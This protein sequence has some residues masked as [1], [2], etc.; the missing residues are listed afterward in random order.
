MCR[1]WPGGELLAVLPVFGDQGHK[2][3]R[4]VFGEGCVS[5][6]KKLAQIVGQLPGGIQAYDRRLYCGLN[7]RFGK[8]KRVDYRRVAMLLDV[9][10][11]HTCVFD[12]DQLCVGW[13]R[14]IHGGCW[15]ERD[16]AAR[17]TPLTASGDA[18]ARSPNRV[19]ARLVCWT[20]CAWLWLD[21][22]EERLLP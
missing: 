19:S 8:W 22:D 21:A 17:A 2:L 1:H 10:L 7:D 16:D 5:R 15:L 6:F 4:K 11:E 20:T 9:T 18:A 13:I 14:R 3:G 12:N